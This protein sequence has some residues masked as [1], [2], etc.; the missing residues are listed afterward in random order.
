MVF[1]FS[2]IGHVLQCVT[3]KPNMQMYYGAKRVYNQFMVPTSVWM[4]RGLPHPLMLK[5]D[6]VLLV[7]KREG[8]EADAGRRRARPTEDRS[9]AIA[10]P[11]YP[12][13]PPLL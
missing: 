13:F 12:K 8:A 9:I 2:R 3:K 6:A 7:Q 1:F 5:R 4:D 11:P 10:D